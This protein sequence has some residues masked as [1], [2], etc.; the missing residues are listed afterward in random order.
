V[1]GFSRPYARRVQGVP[2]AVKL[3]AATGTFTLTFYADP[4][5]VEP[6]E[7]F[8]PTIHF[9]R[10]IRIDA[11]GCRIVSNGQGIVELAADSAGERTVRISR[12]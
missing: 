11:P 5:I 3:D 9:P 1:K 12:L 10:G 7:I 6:T 8:V 2:N 4:K